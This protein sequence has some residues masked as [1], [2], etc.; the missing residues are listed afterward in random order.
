MDG[1]NLSRDILCN[2]EIM[3]KY[4]KSL[5]MSKI[6][7]A[8]YNGDQIDEKYQCVAN[9]IHGSAPITLV[10]ERTNCICK[11]RVSL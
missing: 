5:I 2:Q 10:S 9:T 6:Y 3:L 8:F 4:D 1:N 7:S 11:F